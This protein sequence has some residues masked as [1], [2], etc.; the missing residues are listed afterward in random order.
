MQKLAITAELATIKEQ[1]VTAALGLKMA[2]VCNI[3]RVL[4]AHLNMANPAVADLAE[5][6]TRCVRLRAADAFYA[7][8]VNDACHMDNMNGGFL[9]ELSL[10]M[11]TELPFKRYDR[12]KREADEAARASS[13]QVRHHAQIPCAWLNKTL[14]YIGTSE[15]I[16][17]RVKEEDRAGACVRFGGRSK[18][19][20]SAL[21]LFRIE[22]QGPHDFESRAVG[23]A[24][25]A[26]VWAWVLGVGDWCT[27]MTARDALQKT[28]RWRFFAFFQQDGRHR[29]HTNVTSAGSSIAKGRIALS[30][31]LRPGCRYDDCDAF[32]LDTLQPMRCHLPTIRN[33]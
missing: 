6:L 28:F 3:L 4:E 8:R 13:D 30:P 14:L 12:P 25:E 22:K 29:M 23:D 26:V 20:S 9:N 18:W 2:H 24:V 1:P 27:L 32:I 16:K 21:P 15:R 31:T 7:T 5:H 33:R 19:F 10:R 11:G 17:R